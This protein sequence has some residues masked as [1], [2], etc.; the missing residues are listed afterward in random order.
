M[1]LERRQALEA[2]AAYVRCP[3]CA[4]PVRLG[5][6]QV[7]CGRGHCFNIARQGYVSLVSGRGGPGHRRQRRDGAWRATASSAAG[8]TGR[9]RT[10]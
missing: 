6:N 7:T 5:E 10:P 2:V 4:D 8:T 3:R 9:S 1:L